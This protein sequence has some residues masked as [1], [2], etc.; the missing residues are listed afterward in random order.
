MPDDIEI[1]YSSLRMLGLVAM[2]V[3]MTLLSV[4]IA[5]NWFGENSI[6]SFYVLI[7]YLG[8]A[9]FGFGTVKF[10]WTLLT[11]RGPVL[12]ISRYGI[13]DMRIANELILWDSV[14]AI[15]A[16][17]YRKQKFI[18]LKVGP[19]LE[20]RLFATKMKQALQQASKAMGFDGV[21]ISAGGLATDFDSLLSTCM[22]YYS[23][24]PNHAVGRQ[25]GAMPTTE[26]SSSR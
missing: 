17:D 21:T 12:F 7:A 19:A 16:C 2:A 25:S 5:F 8:I 26:S 15:S 9:F 3:I 20:Q 4:S 6:D 10:I 22:A 13:R 24:R 18:L 11:A 14:E 23:A 1:G